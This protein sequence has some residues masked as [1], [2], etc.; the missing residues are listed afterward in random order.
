M[1]SENQISNEHITNNKTVRNTLISRGITPEN[2][3]PE[4]D[5]KKVERKLKSDDKKSLKNLLKKTEENI[6]DHFADVNKTI[7]MPKNTQKEIKDIMLARY[8]YPKL[9]IFLYLGIN[10]YLDLLF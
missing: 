1:S 7:E 2:L 4:E 8:A 3:P 6:I 9:I 10:P 5:V